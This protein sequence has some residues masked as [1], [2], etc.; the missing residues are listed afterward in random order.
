MAPGPA[1]AAPP[2]PQII[3]FGGGWGPEGTQQ[4]LEAQVDRLS[5]VLRSTTPTVLFADGG[6]NG[7]SVQ[8]PATE[9]ATTDLLGLIFNRRQDL[10]SD[11][12]AT[13]LTPNGAANRSQ[14]IQ[15]LQASQNHRG[16]TIVIGVGHGSPAEDEIEA[17]IELWGIDDRLTPT[18]LAAVLDKRRAGP[19]AFVLGQC[20]SGAF[21]T[22]AYS[23]AKDSQPLARPARC[24][25][26]AVPADREASGCT[27]DLNSASAQAYVSRF[28]E[29]LTNR[30]ADFNG[31]G[32]VALFEAHA[33]AKIHDDTVDVPVSSLDLWVR[34][35]IGEAAPAV[36]SVDL[37]QVLTRVDRADAAVLTALGRQYV[38]RSN[39]ITA[40]EN[41]FQAL[42]ATIE[43]KHK[44]FDDLQSRFETER[45][46][47]LDRL[48]AEWPELTN[49]YHPVSRALL[50]GPAPI[51]VRWLKAQAELPALLKLDA[52]LAEVDDRVLAAEKAAARLERWLRTA[53]TAV[54]RQLL[55]QRGRHVDELN[56]LQ[57][58]GAMS[59]LAGRPLE[60]K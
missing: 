37:R 20:H 30:A 45:R 47:I 52:S 2:A 13:R 43:A 35:T 44:A 3:I 34:A 1:R 26:A 32:R 39:G 54:D 33:Y 50:A 36:T 59:P 40:A 10:H 55:R 17:A 53:Q 49:P 38:G 12:R 29:A 58:C 46:T 9:D 6:G 41:D 5:A 11:Y 23:G 25:F 7:R 24:V 21:T 51:V 16:G 22:L 15:A 19:T 14:I 57:A 56:A 8:I 31:D 28:T 18:G 48:L 60:K 4:S 42:Q 27:A